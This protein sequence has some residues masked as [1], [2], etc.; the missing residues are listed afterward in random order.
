MAGLGSALMNASRLL[1]RAL[2][3]ATLATIAT[4]HAHSSAPDA[5]TSHSPSASAARKPS[6]QIR[7]GDL[8]K[9]AHVPDADR[10]IVGARDDLQGSELAMQTGTGASTGTGF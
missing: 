5:T 3:L 8:T 6:L 2:G 7:S 9:T 1:G 10:A 4:G